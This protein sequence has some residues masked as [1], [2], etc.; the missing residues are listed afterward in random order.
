[1]HESEEKFRKLAE[2]ANDGVIIMDNDANIIFWNKADEEIF[3]YTKKE[4]IGK[5]IYSLLLRPEHHQSFI[6]RFDHFSKTGEGPFIDKTFQKNIVRRDGTKLWIDVSIFSI[7]LEGKWNT[8]GIIRNVAK[9]KQA[10][11]MLTASEEKYR[12]IVETAREGIWV[13]DT[14]MRTTYVNK[15]ITEMLGYSE[16]EMLGKTI[17]DFMDN[18][19]LHTKKQN[20]EQQKSGL[21]EI[22]DLHLLRKDGSDLW[23]IVSMSTMLDEN[24]SFI[25]SF[26]MVTDITKRKEIEGK[27]NRA[28]SRMET[29]SKLL[30]ESQEAERR[31]IA[32]E[33]HDEI[34]QSLTALKINFQSVQSLHK[35]EKNIPHIKDGIEIIDRLIEQVRNLSFDLR[36]SML[37][38]LGLVSALKWYAEHTVKHSGIKVKF[39]A[40]NVNGNLSPDIETTCFRVATE[41]LTNVIRHSK[42]KEVNIELY[43]QDNELHL[44]IKDDGV[45][46][47]PEKIRAKVLQGKSLGLLGMEERIFLIHGNLKLKS[48][49]NQGT[50]VHARFPLTTLDNLKE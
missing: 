10:E 42:A 37:D 40:N 7:D 22:D 2:S 34:G 32:R 8:I 4:V 14:R 17:F 35:K 3:G 29:L 43:E 36:P 16:A 20:L 45:G 33:L 49:L 31:R 9:Q 18:T 46:F 27:L 50:E 26:A 48:V 15:Q 1:L 47:D 11:E 24:S 39:I 44:F 41:A 13:L 6:N 5:K 23:V 12:Q 25:G 28:M 19:E 21:K 30:I 38:D